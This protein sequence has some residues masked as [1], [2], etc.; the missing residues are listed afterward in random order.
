MGK[1]ITNPITHVISLMN[2]SLKPNSTKYVFKLSLTTIVVNAT[3]ITNLLTSFK[4]LLLNFTGF[5]M[6]K[7][8]ECK[9]LD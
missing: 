8:R 3:T 2:K 6:H 5:K 1:A 4:T 7:A 9:V